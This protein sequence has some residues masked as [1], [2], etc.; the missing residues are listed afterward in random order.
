[1]DRTTL[2]RFKIEEAQNRGGSEVQNR[3]VPH[4]E[5]PSR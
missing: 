1:M 2:R 4:F 5:I 3:F